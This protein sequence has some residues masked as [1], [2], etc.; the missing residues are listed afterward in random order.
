MKSIIAGILTAAAFAT[1]AFVFAQQVAPETRAEVKAELKQVEQ[2]GYQPARG[3]DP[4]YPSDIQK[5]ERKISTEQ[6]GMVNDSLGGAVSSTSASGRYASRSKPSN[7][8]GPAG[9]CVPYFGS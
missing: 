1:P 9:F 4:D 3:E 7:C 2:A 8:V 6:G 5:A